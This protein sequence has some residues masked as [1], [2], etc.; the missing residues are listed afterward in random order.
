[1]IG[2]G[3]AEC[4]TT[5]FFFFALPYILN[6][7]TDMSPVQLFTS[8]VAAIAL[9]VM[10]G[11]VL[12]CDLSMLL[13]KHIT[14]IHLM[15]RQFLLT[16]IAVKYLIVLGAALLTVLLLALFKSTVLLCPT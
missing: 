12:L 8:I 6:A 3:A 13:M 4:A 7:R 16:R 2:S 5:L 15:G 9:G 10:L 14:H 1:M 11:K